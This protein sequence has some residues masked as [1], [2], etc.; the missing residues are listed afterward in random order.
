[1]KDSTNIGKIVEI[2]DEMTTDYLDF[3]AQNNMPW[4]CS[5]CGMVYCD[6]MPDTCA[7]DQER[8]NCILKRDKQSWKT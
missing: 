6:G 8:C 3:S 7:Y 1:M 4:A 5:D 2:I